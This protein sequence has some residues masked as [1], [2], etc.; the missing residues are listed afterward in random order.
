[1]PDLGAERLLVIL[2]CCHAGGI[3][4][5]AIKNSNEQLQKLLGQ[6]QGKITIAACLDGEFS[7]ISNNTWGTMLSNIGLTLR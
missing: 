1:L 6:G 7:Y 2:D 4:D 3:K 5:A